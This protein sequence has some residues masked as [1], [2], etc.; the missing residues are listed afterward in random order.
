[1]RVTVRVSS[2]NNWHRERTL[3]GSKA[4]KLELVSHGAVPHTPIEDQG[5]PLDG[6]PDRPVG[7]ATR[8]R[9][10]HMRAKASERVHGSVGGMN[11][12]G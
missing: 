5:P 10:N 8:R 9:A 2:L 6:Q 12:E 11:P 4:L 1:M 3:T 7:T